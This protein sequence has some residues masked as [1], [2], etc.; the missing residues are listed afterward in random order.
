MALLACNWY[1]FEGHG[2]GLGNTLQV[3]SPNAGVIFAWAYQGFG[4]YRVAQGW[5]GTTD[6]GA[7]I[8]DSMA[9]FQSLYPGFV[10]IDAN[11]LEYTD[12]NTSAVIDAYFDQNDLLSEL[13]VQ[14]PPPYGGPYINL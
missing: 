10:V 9:S 1:I 11:H 13:L 5:T 2:G 3:A 8:G 6:K 4:E 14:A 12:P 7:K